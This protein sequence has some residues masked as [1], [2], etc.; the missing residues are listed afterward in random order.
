MQTVAKAKA[1]YRV[2]IWDRQSPINRVPAAD[3]LSARADIPVDGVVYLI[4]R[5]NQVLYFQPHAPNA[6]GFLPMTTDEATI[7]A[8]Q[9]VQE[10]ACADISPEVVVAP[11]PAGVGATVTFTASLPTDT[12]DTQVSFRVDGGQTYIEP[13]VNGQASH[14]YA[15]ATAGTYHVEVSSPSHA[16]TMIE[17]VAQ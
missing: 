16:P 6:P 2:E 8:N 9:K 11:K 13:I 17:V 1:A 4:Y 3:V 15:F 14:A 7:Y 10:L 5:D 12:P